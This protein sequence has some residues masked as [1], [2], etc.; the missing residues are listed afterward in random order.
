[1]DGNREGSGRLFRF[2]T[3]F[4]VAPS[5]ADTAHDYRPL[6]IRSSLIDSPAMTRSPHNVPPTEGDILIVDDS[7]INLRLLS[8][9]LVQ[10]GYRV[11]C[12]KTGAMALMAA[13]TDPPDLI[14]LDVRMPG[15]DGY[16]VCEQL[17]ADTRTQPIPVIFLS[18]LG[19]GTDKVK[20]FAV[21]GADYIAKPFHMEEVFARIQ[22]QLTIQRLQQQLIEQ[23]HLLRQAKEAAEVANQAKGEFLARMSHELH[24]PL[25]AIL[26]Y[27]RLMH[28]DDNLTAEQREGLSIINYSGEHLLNLVKDVLNAAKGEAGNI[29]LEPSSF[30]L[31][32]LL[33]SVE[34]MFRLKAQ[35]KGL[36]LQ[37]DYAADSP[38]Y[39]TTDK[40][41]LLQVMLNL[42]SNAVKFT[43]T[44]GVVLSVHRDIDETA[45]GGMLQ[46]Q[47]EDT[48]V[49]IAADE[50]AHL[51]QPFV[52]ST[53]GRRSRQGTG[54]GLAI[55]YDFVKLMGG[56]IHLSSQL[57]VGTVVHVQIP[58]Q[59]GQ[60][61]AVGNCLG[62]S[63]GLRL[64]AEEPAYRLLVVEGKWT[65]RRLLV[66]WLRRWGFAVQEA[67]TGQEATEIW[68]SWQPHLIWMDMQ[69]PTLAGY[70]TAQ[71]IKSHLQGQATVMIA[72]MA[73]P[74]EKDG[75]N[76]QGSGCDDFVV[77]PFQETVIQAKLTQHLR[78]TFTAADAAIAPAAS[79][80]P[81]V[82][83]MDLTVLPAD[84]R[85]QFHEATS[86][87][88][89]PAMLQLIRQIQ[90]QH[91]ALAAALRSLTH[92]FQYESLLALTETPE[93]HSSQSLA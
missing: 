89:Q 42:L 25:N 1:M 72:L 59:R 38:Q 79:P 35:A 4:Q 43:E 31:S 91:P 7:P 93:H 51:F 24:T 23:N 40:G 65:D 50:L 53:A 69:T 87:L 34:E 15:L 10:Q 56:D 57:N 92:D 2:A 74:C 71:H 66:S 77:K 82:T 63:P 81:T 8:Q 12:V 44:G 46:F 27:S 73:A 41:K 29:R 80:P 6:W 67:E 54:L 28:Q 47:V 18:A 32:A 21:G 84:W 61:D 49:G 17:K 70:E 39:I 60:P 45:E 26:G 37:I 9:A 52:Q 88:N 86:D 83:A 3:R 78:A 48:G 13:R 5:L 14:L 36:T 68:Q 75:F 76:L 85:R 30:D 62:G 11:R 55:S 58:V 64:A 16:A 90:G 22:H 20:G 33:M 19:N